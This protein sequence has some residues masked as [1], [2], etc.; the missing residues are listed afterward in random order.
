LDWYSGGWIGGRM[1]AL[2]LLLKL[3]N[4][5]TRIVSAYGPVATRAQMQAELDAL[6]IVFDRMVELIRKGYTT[7][8][9]IESGVMNGLPRTWK[10]PQKFVY[11]THKGFWAHHNTLSHDIV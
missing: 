11:D 9:M 6:T 10:D 3:S 1:D 7:Q 2:A 4:D 8:D 5:Q